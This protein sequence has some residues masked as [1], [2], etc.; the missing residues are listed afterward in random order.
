M[1]ETPHDVEDFASRM[2][3]GGVDAVREMCLF[4]EKSKGSH[5]RVKEVAV[6]WRPRASPTRSPAD[7]RWRFTAH[8]AERGS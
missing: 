5:E 7:S 4:C 8:I 2:R 3:R 6:N 1:T